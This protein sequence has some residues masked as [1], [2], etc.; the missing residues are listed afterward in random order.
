MDAKISEWNLG[1]TQ[2]I[3]EDILSVSSQVS[4]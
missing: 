4:Y 1:E 3:C 2:N